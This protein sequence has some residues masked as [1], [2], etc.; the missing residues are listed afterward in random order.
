MAQEIFRFMTIRPPQEVDPDTVMKNT[1]NL[2]QATGDFI[3]SLVE[4]KKAGSREGMERLVQE[5]LHSNDAG[6]IDARKKV[7]GRF[8]T[9]YESLLRLEEHEFRH[10]AKCLFTNIFNVEL[11]EFVTTNDF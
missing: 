3:A 9:F 5:F 6:F 4:Q 10:A 2:N 7:D 1:V 11:H 8:L